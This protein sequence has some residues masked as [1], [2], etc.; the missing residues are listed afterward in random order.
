[1]NYNEKVANQ[2]NRRILTVFHSELV[3][4]LETIEQILILDIVKWSLIT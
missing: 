3:S 2:Q 4:Y 1:M